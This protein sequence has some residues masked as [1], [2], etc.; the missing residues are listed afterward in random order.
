M[1]IVDKLKRT[2]SVT[3]TAML[4]LRIM[5]ALFW[6]VFL[7]LP[8]AFFFADSGVLPAT[9]PLGDI[10]SSGVVIFGEAGFRAIFC[11]VWFAIEFSLFWRFVL[12]RRPTDSTPV[13]GLAD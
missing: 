7:V 6:T 9:G 5:A 12:S 2:M 10:Y 13:E 1:T 3:S 4:S 11:I 8:I